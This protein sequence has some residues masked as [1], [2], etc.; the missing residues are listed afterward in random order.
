MTSVDEIRSIFKRISEIQ[1]ELKSLNHDNYKKFR[2]QNSEISDL[3]H[4]NLRKIL[5]DDEFEPI[6]TLE[7]RKNLINK[8]QEK[9]SQIKRSEGIADESI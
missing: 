9:I 2:E 6:D 8:W 5:R 3:E 7:M 4:Y 1:T